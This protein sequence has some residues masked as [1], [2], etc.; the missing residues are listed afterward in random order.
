MAEQERFR[1][2]AFVNADTYKKVSAI[3]LEEQL[4]N[5]RK[6]SK[7]EVLDKVFKQIEK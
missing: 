2:S 4:K 6:P 3:Q 7:G 1:I 5:G